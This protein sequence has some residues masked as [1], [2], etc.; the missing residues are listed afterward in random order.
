M[1]GTHQQL[2][3]TESSGSFLSRLKGLGER[4]IETVKRFF[5]KYKERV[6]FP[7]QVQEKMKNNY[8]EKPEIA[9]TG[10][11][12]EA[13]NQQI[14]DEMKLIFHSQDPGEYL[15]SLGSMREKQAVLSEF[16]EKL[17]EIYGLTDIDVVAE[18]MDTGTAGYYT[19][20]EK[21]L[22]FN[23]SYLTFDNP[24]LERDLVDT[25]LHETRHAVQFAAM[26]GNNKVG[27]DDATIIEWVKNSKN[28]I[29]AENDP[30]GYQNQPLE[31]DAWSAAEYCMYTYLHSI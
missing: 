5:R 18:Y 30:V 11:K 14:V 1:A 27:F 13:I 9:A 21:S 31:A 7:P 24:L 8:K 25:L 3:T 16:A 28:Y 26:D 29:R 19:W 20:K 15:A 2:S 22:H 23:M 12:S 10:E 6:S 4:I 17:F